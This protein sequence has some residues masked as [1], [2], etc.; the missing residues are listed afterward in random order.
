MRLPHKI[1]TGIIL[2]TTTITFRQRGGYN[3]NYKS[4]PYTGVTHDRKD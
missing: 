1:Q 2:S 3:K 4:N